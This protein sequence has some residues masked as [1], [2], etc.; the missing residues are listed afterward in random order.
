MNQIKNLIN[1]KSCNFD[2]T[3]WKIIKFHF[4]STYIVLLQ[5]QKNSKNLIIS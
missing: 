4:S 1:K 2:P 5:F 3:I